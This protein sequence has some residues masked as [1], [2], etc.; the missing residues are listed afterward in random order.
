[1]ALELATPYFMAIPVSSKQCLRINSLNP[2]FHV[3]FDS[4]I[5]LNTS[6]ILA[7]LPW[8]I[9]KYQPDLIIFMVGVNNWWNLNKSNILL[10]NKDRTVSGATLRVLI[11][12]DRFRIWKR[13]KWI[14][15]SKGFIKY[16]SD[17]NFPI[18]PENGKEEGTNKRMAIGL[19]LWISTVEN[20][21]WPGI[22]NK[23]GYHDIGEM[24][25]I[26]KN[27]KIKIIICNYPGDCPMNDIQKRVSE[28]L[29]VP[30]VDNNLVFKNLPNIEEHIRVDQFHPA[31]KGYK[32]VAEIFINAS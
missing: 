13:I 16:A 11:L 9:E 10:F 3:F 24:V 6:E 4:S 14:G 25:R 32:V 29:N 17:F 21:I 27:H 20:K 8:Y 15:Y 1:M 18:E 23:I 5:G 12:L 31:D 22:F 7:R 30:F 28:E 19:R 2:I 26:S